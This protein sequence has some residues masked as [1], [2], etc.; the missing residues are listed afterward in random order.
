MRR[1]SW[2]HITT[3]SLFLA[4]ALILALTLWYLPNFLELNEFRPQVLDFLQK[5]FHCHVIVG[6]IRGELVPYPGLIVEH[7]V[8]LEESSAARQ[9]DARRGVWRA[10]PRVLASVNGV[11]LWFSRK[12][13]EGRL[14]FR[15][16]RFSRPR[17][18]VHRETESSGEKRWTFLSVPGMT[19]SS[20][21]PGGGG[22]LVDEWQIRNGSVEY[23]DHAAAA[24]HKWVA[25]QFNGS[26]LTGSQSG[27][28]TGKVPR[29]GRQAMLDLH[30]TGAAVF[31]LE[32]HLGAVELSAI[33]KETPLQVPAFEDTADFLV[34]ARFEP[35]FAVQATMEPMLLPH[36]DGK[37]L[38][39]RAT[40][41]KDHLHAHLETLDAAPMTMEVDADIGKDAWKARAA[42]T[43]YDAALVR[44]F[45]EQSWVDRLLGP[46]TLEAHAQSGGSGGWNWS[47]LGKDFRM[48]GTA[49]RIPEWSARGDSKS[50]TV[51]AHGVTAQGG[52]ADVVWALPEASTVATLQVDADSVTLRQVLEVFNLQSKPA[53]AAAAQPE[54][55]MNPFGYEPWLITKGS[56]RALLH[57][58]TMFEIQ[59]SRF[60][61]A[62]MQ[63]NLSGTFELTQLNPHAHIQGDVQNIAVAPVV[64]SFFKPP[65]PV[66]GT[67]KI[68][69]TLAFPMS[70]SWIQGLSGPI[71]LEIDNGLIRELKTIYRIMTVLNLS[72]YLRLR[73]PQITARGI[74]FQTLSGHL[75]FQNGVLSSEDLFSKGPTLNMGARGSVNIPARRI[76]ISL[77]LEMFRF[78]EDILKDVPITHWMFKKPSKILLPLVVVVDGPWDNVEIR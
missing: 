44:T 5:T 2:Y 9:A 34:K 20:A 48:E 61:I 31:P 19:S 18:I 29:L 24:T 28:I 76:K 32:A 51:L 25:D 40:F 47:A 58:G 59:Q 70:D 30:Y 1:P 71:Q 62:G 3:R 7:V 13:L 39:V 12:I 37:R 16:V 65:S 68:S 14:Q 50:T 38:R 74:Q 67:G 27:S 41:E 36:T 21:V 69:F 54:D 22:A 10:A 17:F 6:D 35:D 63:T 56:M 53:S 4:A 77:R 78:L 73:F 45:Y 49:L 75:T 55:S 64:E 52:T 60:V 46:G 8:F 15:A 66:T 72:N 23:W 33:G 57:N 11:H 42:V 43:G 26:F